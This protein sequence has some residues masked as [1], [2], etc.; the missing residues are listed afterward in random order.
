MRSSNIEE[1]GVNEPIK[2]VEEAQENSS[3]LKTKV[4]VS[5]K[6]GLTPV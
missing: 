3:S 2:R 5:R 4:R 6:E 1:S